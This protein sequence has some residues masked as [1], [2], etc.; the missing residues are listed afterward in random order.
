MAAKSKVVRIG[1]REF[2]IFQ[3]RTKPARRLRNR[4]LAV[5][6]PP[7]AQALSGLK[8]QAKDL[9]SLLGAD[10][11]AFA[12]AISQLFQQLTPEQEEEFVG[13]LLTGARVRTD[14]GKFVD[15][16]ATMMEDAFA[17]RLKDQD[18]LV[19]EAIKLNYDDFIGAFIAAVSAAKQEAEPAT[20]TK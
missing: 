3:L 14:S 5:L 8:G 2:E 9:R 12:P 16:D 1:D 13:Q 11:S 17:G 15:L 20:E 6:A 18:L 7:F 4:L 19:V 10:T